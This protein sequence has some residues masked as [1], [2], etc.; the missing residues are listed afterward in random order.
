MECFSFQEY[1]FFC[2]N[3]MFANILG[4]D[5]NWCSS[6]GISAY[7]LVFQLFSILRWSLFDYALPSFSGVLGR[8]QAAPATKKC[9]ARHQPHCSAM[10]G[11]CLSVEESSSVRF[12][13]WC[14]MLC[15]IVWESSGHRQGILLKISN[16]CSFFMFLS[17]W[18]VRSWKKY[19]RSTTALSVFNQR[20]LDQR[21]H[22][23]PTLPAP[24]LSTAL[25]VYITLHS[26]VS[27]C[28]CKWCRKLGSRCRESLAQDA[29]ETLSILDRCPRKLR[30]WWCLYVCAWGDTSKRSELLNCICNFAEQ[31]LDT[32]TRRWA[33]YEILWDIQIKGWARYKLQYQ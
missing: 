31:K 12:S 17:W 20:P 26:D 19:L 22:V 25:F 8:F 23:A 3:M 5:D 30:T 15:R 7:F 21:T 9:A 32:R 14:R 10:S 4:I 28:H 16:F 13:K 24:A 18:Q 27:S 29:E 1:V 2:Y 6:V 11:G 33:K